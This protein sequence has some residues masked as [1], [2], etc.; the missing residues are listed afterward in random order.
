MI[1]KG[2][3]KMTIPNRRIGSHAAEIERLKTAASPL[4]QGVSKTFRAVARNVKFV[5]AAK[6][7]Y[8]SMAEL[9]EVFEQ[10]KDESI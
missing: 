1:G 8:E 10:T 5:F 2:H 6:S 7:A 4:R 9:V 3:R